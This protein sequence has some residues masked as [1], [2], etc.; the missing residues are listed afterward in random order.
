MILIRSTIIH[1]IIFNQD[2][3]ANR[4]TFDTTFVIY[5]GITRFKKSMA[6]VLSLL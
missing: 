5:I 1:H 6:H 3:T 4:L 2:L